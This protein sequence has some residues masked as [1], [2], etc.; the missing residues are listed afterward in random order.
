M[1]RDNMVRDMLSEQEMFQAINTMQNLLANV[2]R[3][4]KLVMQNKGGLH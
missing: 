4:I 3:N 2:Y 1:G